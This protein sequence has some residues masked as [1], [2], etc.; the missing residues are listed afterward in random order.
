[1]AIGRNILSALGGMFNRGPDEEDPLAGL[2]PEAL[3]GYYGARSRNQANNRQRTSYKPYEYAPSNARI[4]G[5][6][7]L[8]P[9]GVER[10]SERSRQKGR[11]QF[12]KFDAKVAD[13]RALDEQ[14]REDER[15]VREAQETAQRNIDR[16]RG[17]KEGAEDARSKA[18]RSQE[19][20]MSRQNLTD[21]QS[22]AESDFQ[23]RESR[24]RILKGI[25]Q[26]RAK[27]QAQ[28]QADQDLIDAN[29]QESQQRRAE[30]QFGQDVRRHF[31]TMSR[32]GADRENAR[33]AEMS[34]QGMGRSVDRMKDMADQARM[35]RL[36]GIAQER[37]ADALSN[38]SPMV[39]Q[40][41]PSLVTDPVLRQGLSRK[42]QI[43]SFNLDVNRQLNQQ[44][45]PT[46]EEA[47]EE[48]L[49]K[50]SPTASVEPP[51]ESAVEP[52]TEPTFNEDAVMT[53]DSGRRGMPGSLS[54]ES[55]AD[56]PG[57]S[58]LEMNRAVGK[59]MLPSEPN[60]GMRDF[61]REGERATE[62]AILRGDKD[63]LTRKIIEDSQPGGSAAVYS[64]A[65]NEAILSGRVSPPAVN[66]EN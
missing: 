27:D 22:G 18:R 39:G 1:M 54:A 12:E 41:T 14:R 11:R 24:D 42:P 56:F 45:P 58:D 37:S 31:G 62:S 33:L 19:A 55:I 40:G 17:I 30:G 26:D 61:E 23:D 48:E 10:A 16:R 7:K 21:A 28:E 25:M 53:I 59:K 49:K 20:R 32:M 44:F 52:T 36:V 9:G 4:E 35:K 13:Q 29:R 15:A 38:M 50:T 8:S 51:V 34:K 47:V 65:A 3:A 6:L 5:D 66:E 2:S 43:G 63:A 57:A 64:D 46:P 60:T